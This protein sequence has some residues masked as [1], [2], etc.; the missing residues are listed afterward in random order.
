M[1]VCG[2]VGCAWVGGGGG[3]VGGA[4]GSGLMSRVFLHVTRTQLPDMAKD[5]WK[6]GVERGWGGGGG[7]CWGGGG[8]R[9]EGVRPNKLYG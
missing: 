9:M 8:V 3:G 6:C 1:Y 7:G 4:G 2:R 5:R